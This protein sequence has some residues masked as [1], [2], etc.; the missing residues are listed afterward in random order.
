MSLRLINAALLS[1][2]LITA[3]LQAAPV[4]GRLIGTVQIKD[5]VKLD[6][7]AT[8]Q[9]A[10]IASKIRKSGHKGAIKLKGDMSSAANEA[11]YLLKSAIMAR[12]VETQLKRMLSGR[13][14]IFIAAPQYSGESKPG[15]SSVEITLYPHELK[16]ETEGFTSAQVLPEGRPEEGAAVQEQPVQPVYQQ[17]TQ[18]GLLTPPPDDDAPPEVT[19]KK[20]RVKKETENPAL[21]NELVLKAKA[22]AAAKAKRLEQGN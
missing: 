16:V 4:P 3:P 10:S 17:S 15:V 18:S 9:L 14:Q 20:E 21:A 7:A 11:E 1:V 19:S 6:A 12:S 8:R 22:R 13:Q 2:V 5:P